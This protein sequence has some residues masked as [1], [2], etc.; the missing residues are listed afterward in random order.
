MSATS[1]ASPPLAVPKIH[2]SLFASLNFDRYANKSSL[3]L[4]LAAVGFVAQSRRATK[5]RYTPIRTFYL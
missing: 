1:S 2:S 4:P 5:L 3:S